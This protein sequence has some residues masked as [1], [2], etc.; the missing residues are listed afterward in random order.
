MLWLAPTIF[1]LLHWLWR[2]WLWIWLVLCLF[3][4]ILALLWPKLPEYRSEVEQLLN[5][6]LKQPIT[7][8]NLETY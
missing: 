4:L 7:I 5:T 3:I 8:G 6:V 2:L 1:K